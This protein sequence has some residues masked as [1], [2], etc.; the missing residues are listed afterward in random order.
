VTNK[1]LGQFIKGVLENIGLIYIFILPVYF[2]IRALGLE[3]N[4]YNQ[5]LHDSS[6]LILFFSQITIVIAFTSIF[7]SLFMDFINKRFFADKESL[8][9]HW[10]RFIA[11]FLSIVFILSSYFVLNPS[12]KF[13]LYFWSGGHYFIISFFQLLIRVELSTY[14]NNLNISI[15]QANNYFGFSLNL[16]GVISVFIFGWFYEN[17]ELAVYSQYC[18]FLEIIFVLYLLV[19]R[20]Y[21]K[22]FFQLVSKIGGIRVLSHTLVVALAL[23]CSGCI[24]IIVMSIGVL[25]PIITIGL[26]CGI[27]Q[28]YKKT[29][30]TDDLKLLVNISLGYGLI[31]AVFTGSVLTYFIHNYHGNMGVFNFAYSSEPFFSLILGIIMAWSLLRSNTEYSRNKLYQQASYINYLVPL[32]F[33]IFYGALIGEKSI[34]FLLITMFGVYAYVEYMSMFLMRQVAQLPEY[35]TFQ[36]ARLAGFYTILLN[37]LCPSLIYLSVYGC[38]Q[39]T[40][41]SLD[42][43]LIATMIGLLVISMGYNLKFRYRIT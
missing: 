22:D 35:N 8:I 27:Y 4:S 9:I 33:L 38:T 6:H 43:M 28:N 24:S 36:G 13:E 25:A 34:G 19:A 31:L 16:V 14:K 10:Y 12:T 29:L 37:G 17:N 32:V 26:I 1:I 23:I 42:T 40:N 21:W 15:A 11:S 30:K 41:L 7:L 39:L 18:V 5:V 20:R 3:L 2:P